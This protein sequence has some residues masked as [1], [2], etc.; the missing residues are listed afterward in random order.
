MDNPFKFFIQELENDNAQV[1]INAMVRLP[2]I[3][4]SIPN[5]IDKKTEIL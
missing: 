4:Y 2:I 1:K 5:H 3:I